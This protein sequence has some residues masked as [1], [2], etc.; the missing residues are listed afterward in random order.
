MNKQLIKAYYFT[1]GI[2]ALGM[3]AF[4]IYTG[5]QTVSYGQTISNLEK[6]RQTLVAQQTSLQQQ[7]GQEVSLGPA[8]ELAQTDGYVLTT[9][10]LQLP[11]QTQVALR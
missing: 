3:G 2:I 6:Q 4:T 11:A 7:I 8:Q 1:L 9:Q 10:L 5:S